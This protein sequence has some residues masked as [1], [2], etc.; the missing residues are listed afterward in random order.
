M[1]RHLAHPYYVCLLSAA[2]AHGYAH[3]RPQVFQVMTTAHVRD[4]SFGRVHLRFVTSRH[5]AGRPT[6]DVNTPTGTM[7]VSTPEVTVLDLVS[8]P[9]DSG[10]LYN[11]GT[12]IGDMLDET[13]LDI[14]RLAEATDTYPTAIAQGTGWMIDTAAASLGVE[15][16]TGPLLATVVGA[17][18]VLLDPS[19]PRYGRPDRRWNVIAN[20]ELELES[21]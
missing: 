11:V 17:A 7:R 9:G 15:V 3:Q 21:S 10:S 14:A 19:G 20:A 18:P 16:D 6:V 2:E 13:A 5:A 4:R 12:I 8:R 1:M